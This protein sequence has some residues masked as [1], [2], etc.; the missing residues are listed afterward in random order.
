MKKLILRKLNES[1]EVVN[2]DVLLLQ[3]GSILI[4]KY[5]KRMTQE[6]ITYIHN[7]VK[8]S[9]PIDVELISIPEDIELNILEIQ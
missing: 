5:P 9:L 7:K 4:Q 1:G 8:L 3:E 6:E 2:E